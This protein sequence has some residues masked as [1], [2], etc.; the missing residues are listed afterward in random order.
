MSQPPSTLDPRIAAYLAN[1]REWAESES[2]TPP[3]KFEEMQ[4]KGR[5][6][7]DGTVIVGSSCSARRAFA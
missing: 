1:N 5:E 6:R 2:Y 3:I 7:K 4:K